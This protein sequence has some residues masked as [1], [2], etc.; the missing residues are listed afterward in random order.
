MKNPLSTI[1]KQ[2]P[3]ASIPNAISLV[4]L[5]SVLIGIH[6]LFNDQTLMAIVFITFSNVFDSIDG[7]LARRFKMFSPIGADLDSS[8]DVIAFLIPPFIIAVLSGSTPFIIAA[9]FFVACG[10]F[11]IARFAAEEKY[12]DGYGKGMQVCITAQFLYLPVILGFS[13]QSLSIIYI[14]LSLLMLSAFPIKANSSTV[15]NLILMIITF[16]LAT[17][18][19]I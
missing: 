14:I 3:N 8:I 12:A 10:V 19:L 7:H 1:Q 17:N 11:R 6:L 18:L 16:I 13:S 9:G 5:A 15:I 4:G 2:F